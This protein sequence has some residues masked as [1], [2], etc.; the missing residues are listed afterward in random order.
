MLL[1]DD[2]RAE[3]AKFLTHHATT[4]FSMD[5]ALAHVVTKAYQQG[6]ADGI[7]S[8]QETLKKDEKN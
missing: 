7:A 4:R 8:V 6:L 3:F 2:V 5:Q 1:L